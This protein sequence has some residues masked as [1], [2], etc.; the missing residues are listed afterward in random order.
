M[1]IFLYNIIIWDVN[2]TPS[3]LKTF[4]YLVDFIA[5][6]TKLII[7][8]WFPTAKAKSINVA[9]SSLRSIECDSS[10]LYKTVEKHLIISIESLTMTLLVKEF[11]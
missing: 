11:L 6:T 9:L 2:V 5:E 3:T 4:M 10:F 7:I 8:G 1:L